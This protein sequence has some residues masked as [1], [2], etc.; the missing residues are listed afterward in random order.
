[1][2]ER[3]WQPIESAPKDGSWFLGY[4]PDSNMAWAPYELISWVAPNPEWGITTG[5]YCQDDTSEETPCTMWMPL[6]SPP[7]LMKEV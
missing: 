3:E 2:S 5:Y 4:D 1:M 7:S 6:P